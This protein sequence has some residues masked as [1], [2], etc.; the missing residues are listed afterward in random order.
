MLTG[1]PPRFQRV[2]ERIESRA[3]EIDAAGEMRWRRGWEAADFLGTGCT[4]H[5][6]NQQAL[7][8]IG[9]QQF[10]CIRNAGGRARERHDAVRL[11]LDR[12][13]FA[14]NVPNEPDKSTRE[15]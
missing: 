5:A 1:P 7:A 11:R 3:S 15:K 9:R 13:L 4:V 6:S 12:H 2:A 10:D 8:A 14:C